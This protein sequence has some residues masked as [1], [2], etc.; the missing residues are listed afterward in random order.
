MVS[1][2]SWSIDEV[3][4]SGRGTAAAGEATDGSGRCRTNRRGAD[5]ARGYG[6]S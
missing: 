3:A 2:Q 1:M 6:E 5:G 4:G